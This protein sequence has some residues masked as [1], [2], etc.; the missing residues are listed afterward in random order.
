MPTETRDSTGPGPSSTPGTGEDPVLGAPQRQPTSQQEFANRPALGQQ[1]V[2]PAS[3]QSTENR[4]SPIGRPLTVRSDLPDVFEDLNLRDAI[5][6]ALGN[7]EVVRSLGGQ[8]IQNPT[9]V[10]TVFDVD[11]RRS[12]PFFGE[13]ASLAPFDPTFELNSGFQKNDDVFNNILIGGGANEVQQDLFN[14]NYTLAQTSR[15][16]T[17][18]AISG[19]TQHDNNNATQNLFDHAW[20]QSLEASIRQPLL[21][22]AGIEFNEL[23]G[24]QSG[25]GLRNSN[26]IVLARLNTE[27]SQA[28]FERNVRD[29]VQE[30]IQAYWQLYFAYRSYEAAKEAHESA[31]EIWET[32]RTRYENNLPGGEADREAFARDRLIQ[33]ETRMMTLISGDSSRSPGIYQAEANLRRLMG[34]GISEDEILLRPSDQ[35]GDVELPYDWQVLVQTALAN[36]VE[37]QEQELRVRQRENEVLVARNFTLPRLDAVALWRNNGF[38]DDRFGSGLIPG[39]ADQRFSSSQKDFYSL[40]H[41]EW[42]F[43]LQFAVPLGRRLPFEA[44][45]NAEINLRKERAVLQEMREE[46]EFELAQA[47]RSFDLAY[48]RLSMADRQLAAASDAYRARQTLFEIDKISIDDLTTAQ[49]NLLDAETNYFQALTDYELARIRIQQLRGTLLNEVM[50]EIVEPDSY[51]LP[52]PR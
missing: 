18:F 13:A 26:G 30:V 29:F 27:I 32:V 11:L 50:Q 5:A 52:A 45:R 35:P 6:T 46:V 39:T 21:Q 48:F 9:A 31:R 1:S 17:R 7:T 49:Q 22:G 28:Q 43:N 20:T 24:P 40:D 4:P 47:L 42:E 14:W 15:A 19:L 41:Q 10:A 12:D 34:I 25:L 36:R 16:G 3:Y 8:I 23:A 51:L 33:L 38:G 2:A 37:L 44:L